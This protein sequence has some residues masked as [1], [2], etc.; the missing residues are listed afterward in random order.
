MLRLIR[1]RLVAGL[2]SRGVSKADAEHAVGQLG[3]GTI[4]KWLL[5]HGPDLLSLVE[6]LLALFAAAK[7][8]EVA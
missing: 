8:P 2:T 3:D 5:D 7:A 1:R 6:S 4:L